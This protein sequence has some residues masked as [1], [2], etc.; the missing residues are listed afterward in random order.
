MHHDDA[1]RDPLACTP[2]ETAGLV[3]N[4]TANS[5]VHSRDWNAPCGMV[6]GWRDGLVNRA[7]GIRYATAR[8]WCPPE[9]VAP[10]SQPIQ[11]TAWAPACPQPPMP[12]LDR[13]AGSTVAGLEQSEDCLRVSVTVPS[14][15]HAQANLP[16]MVWVHGGSN[17]SGAGDSPFYDPAALVAEQNVVVVSVTFR[18][19][20]L[21]YLG[22]GKRSAA[23]LGLLDQIEALRWVR[24]NIAAFGGNPE[25]VTLFGHSSGGDAVAHLMISEGTAGLFHRA[26][27]Q[28]APFGLMSGR[29]K[30]TSFMARRVEHLP[31]EASTE[32]LFEAQG[33]LEKKAL[34]F[35]LKG[36]MP[37]G[38]QYGQHPL[39]EE[40]H[41]HDAWRAA[42]QKMDVFVGAT[43][44]EV[45]LFTAEVP[46]LGYSQRSGRGAKALERAIISPLTRVIYGRGATEFAERHG[47]A[48]GKAWE[49]RYSWGNPNS[50]GTA[51]HIAE[52]PLLFPGPVW[53]NTEFTKGC[54]AD[55]IAQAG[56]LLRGVWGDF[57]RGNVPISEPGAGLRVRMAGDLPE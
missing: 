6:I 11:A 13:A 22:D 15:V 23:N 31:E 20:L 33:S 25:N 51:V 7:T 35:G 9:P 29:S 34:R 4:S 48:G 28:S 16:V 46:P 47:Q 54:T 14:G 12:A 43:T 3:T 52:I 39:P 41:V 18:L 55:E 50:P 44:R 21:G 26:I 27:I 37:F 42:A 57:A 36:Q 1:A 56:A 40:S 53:K 49:Y 45:G 10:S 5:T 38:V 32:E 19:G 17:V 8:R 30:M 2:S 24:A